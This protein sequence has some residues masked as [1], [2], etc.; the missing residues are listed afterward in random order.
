MYCILLY[1]HINSVCECLLYYANHWYSVFWFVN[2]EVLTEMLVCRYK[3]DTAHIR[4]KR[5]SFDQE[6]YNRMMRII[7]HKDSVTEDNCMEF[8]VEII[9]CYNWIFINLDFQSYSRLAQIIQ[10]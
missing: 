7:N 6:G 3:R 10:R 1:L 8:K 4:R 9:L 5:Q 2:A